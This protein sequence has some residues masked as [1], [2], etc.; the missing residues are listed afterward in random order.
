M[1]E[2][3]G[4]NWGRPG[5]QYG[6]QYREQSFPQP[7]AAPAWEQ[8]PPAAPS[9]PQAPAAPAWD[10]PAQQPWGQQSHQAPAY[11]Q[12][13]Y[14]QQTP[15]GSPP[16]GYG[17]GPAV[18]YASWGA[19]AAALLLDVLFSVL[20]YV[21]GIVVFVIGAVTGETEEDVNGPVLALG[22][23]LMFAA[24]L[25]MLWN[26]GWRQG[27]VGWSWGKQVVGIKLVRISDAQPPGG[28]LG[29]GRLFLR[30]VLG[31]VTFGVYTLLTYLWPLWDERNQS[32]DD[33]MLSTLVVRA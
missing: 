9:F 7:P 8:Q 17:G 5:D 28:W 25:V 1:T 14:G 11:Q 33:K 15:W 30:A 19:R 18:E 16:P 32:L 23:L 31:N 24:I 26:Q 22:G 13:P 10:Q 12:Q 29:I 27:A 21:P 4:Q 2:G 6:D 3:T 20:L